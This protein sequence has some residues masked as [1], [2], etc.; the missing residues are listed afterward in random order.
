MLASLPLDRDIQPSARAIR[1][2][3]LGAMYGLSGVSGACPSEPPAIQIA[4]GR[5]GRGSIETSSRLKNWP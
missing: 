3:T 1:A 5:G 4:G 2:S